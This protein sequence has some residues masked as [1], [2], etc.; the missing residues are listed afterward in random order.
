METIES[1][2]RTYIVDTF[3]FGQGGDDLSRDESLLERGV[4]DSTGVLEI[5]AFLDEVWGVGVEDEELVPEHFDSI[6][7]LSAFV[8]RKASLA[9]AE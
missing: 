9:A 5:V 4:V 3:L 7:R 6:A 2:I 8:E 1:R